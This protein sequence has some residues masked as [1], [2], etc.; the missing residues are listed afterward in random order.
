MSYGQGGVSNIAHIPNPPSNPVSVPERPGPPIAKPSP[1]RMA[2]SSNIVN[3]ESWADDHVSDAKLMYVSDNAIPSD[4]GQRGN[5]YAGATAPAAAASYNGVP[6]AGGA[7]SSNIPNPKAMQPLNDQRKGEKRGSDGH[8]DPPVSAESYADAAKFKW[9]NVE[10]K[11][12][13]RNNSDNGTTLL[14]VK[15]TP[16]KEIFVK[17]LDYSRCA[18]PADLEGR[19]KLYC[20]K[21][22][23][24]IL[25]A[26][27]FE[28]SDCNRANC[29]VSLKIED[30]EKALSPDFWPQHAT[31]RIHQ[32]RSKIL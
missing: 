28:Q 7:A 10:N 29:R 23:V 8:P 5:N 3:V 18:K 19:V 20:R 17:H 9:D 12:F 13:R 1:K 14:G 11:R 6:R 22:G 31:A 21:R 25:Q 27:V 4:S 16:H 15:S 26:R 30:I 32:T 24:Y 2:I